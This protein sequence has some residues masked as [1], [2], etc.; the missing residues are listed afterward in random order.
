LNTPGSFRSAPGEGTLTKVFS[1]IQLVVV[2]NWQSKFILETKYEKIRLDELKYI[3]NSALERQATTET[4]QLVEF[5]VRRVDYCTDIQQ[6]YSLLSRFSVNLERS[7]TGQ[8]SLATCCESANLYVH[9]SFLRSL[10]YSKFFD[11]LLAASR[12]TCSSDSNKNARGELVRRLLS[13][14][15][16]HGSCFVFNF[17]MVNSYV[18]FVHMADSDGGCRANDWGKWSEGSLNVNKKIFISVMI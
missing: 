16:P 18:H 6:K 9:I 7:E 1:K 13:G 11:T 8:Y 12:Q 2:K 14:Q 17:Q 10:L 15:Q 5:F 3:N 4:Q